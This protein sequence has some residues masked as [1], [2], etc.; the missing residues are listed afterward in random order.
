MS[1]FSESSR[2]AWPWWNDHDE[3][4]KP[5]VIRR[6]I[7]GAHP[8]SLRLRYVA[9]FRSPSLI[10]NKGSPHLPSQFRLSLLLTSIGHSSNNYLRGIQTEGAGTICSNLGIH[11][12]ETELGDTSDTTPLRRPLLNPCLAFIS[13]PASHISFP[14]IECSCSV[15]SISPYI[16]LPSYRF[17]MGI[18]SRWCSSGSSS[19]LGPRV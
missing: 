19:R 12:D 1:V 6:D 16:P 14:S 9:L 4:P 8:W 10:L 11:S 17:S 7:L 2:C 5:D 18:C 15:G 13:H 3:R